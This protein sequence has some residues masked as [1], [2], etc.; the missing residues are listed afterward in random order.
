MPRKPDFSTQ[1]TVHWYYI[2]PTSTSVGGWAQHTVYAI[3][4]VLKIT[5]TVKKIED[6]EQRKR[7][8]GMK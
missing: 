5:E 7:D 2:P 3:E 6:R 8:R 4:D 1:A